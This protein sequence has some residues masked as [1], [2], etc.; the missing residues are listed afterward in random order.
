[1]DDILNKVTSGKKRKELHTFRIDPEIYAQIVRIVKSKGG[2]MS[3]FIAILLEN[4]LEEYLKRNKEN[5]K[6][7]Q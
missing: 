2:N 5:S 1:M 6:W 4:W 3:S 7:R